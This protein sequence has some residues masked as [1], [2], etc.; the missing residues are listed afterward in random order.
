MKR[1]LRTLAWLM[2]AATASS[3]FAEL[4]ISEICPRP[5]SLD[6]NGKESGWIELYNDGTEAVDLKDYEIVRANRGKALEPTGRMLASRTVPAKGYTVVYL[7]NK[8]DN[9]ETGITTV[10]ANGLMVCPCKVSPKK[11]PLVALYKGA[12]EIDR[13]VVPVDLPDNLESERPALRRVE[14]GSRRAAILYSSLNS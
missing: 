3:A 9:A 10:Y 11:F 8:Y 13:F 7:S 4:R 14:S 2:V 6:A 5:T 1:L 12:T